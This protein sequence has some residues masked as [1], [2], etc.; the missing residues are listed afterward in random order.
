MKLISTGRVRCEACEATKT[1]RWPEGYVFFAGKLAPKPPPSSLISLAAI[2]SLLL[3]TSVVITVQLISFFAVQQYDWFIPHNATPTD[4]RSFENYAVFSISALQ[5]VILTIAFHKG[6]PYVGYICSNYI[7]IICLVFITSSTLYLILTPA[8]KIQ[9]FFE[10]K[11]PPEMNFRI[12]VVVL[13]LIN[14]L[15]SLAVEIIVCDYLLSTV[16]KQR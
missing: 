10:L 4:D 9:E 12:L 7:L 3:Q 2:S 8:Q 5:Y 13:G 14:L 1:E 16:L 11:L 6:P 15:L